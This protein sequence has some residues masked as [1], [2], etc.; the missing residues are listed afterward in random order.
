MTTIEGLS[1]TGSHPVQQAWLAEQVT[2]CGYCEPGFIMAI[3]ALLRGEPEPERRADR[4]AAQPLPLRRLS[5]HPQGDRARARAAA[6]HR[7]PPANLQR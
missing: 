3:A 6:Q 7:A 4:G 2:M 1:A 5:A